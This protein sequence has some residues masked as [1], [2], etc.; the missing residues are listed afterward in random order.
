MSVGTPQKP[1]GM[2]AQRYAITIS[3]Y[4][5]EMRNDLRRMLQVFEGADRHKFIS[6][7]TIQGGNALLGTVPNTILEGNPKRTG[8]SVQ[9]ISAS[10]GPTL[11]IGIG[12]RAPQINTGVTLPPGGTWDGRLS[13]RLCTESITVVGSAAATSFTFVEAM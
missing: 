4:L 2:L 8:L 6:G 9:N 7:G 3:T 1:A 5:Q 12:N 11:S 13:G 10:G